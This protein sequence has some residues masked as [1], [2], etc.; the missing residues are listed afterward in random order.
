MSNYVLCFCISATTINV[1]S[2]GDV[3]YD[4]HWYQL[5]HR[6][7]F[8]VQMIIQRS[9]QQFELKAL[10][11]FVCSLDTYLKVIELH[12]WGKN[13]KKIKPVLSSSVVNIRERHVI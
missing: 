9:Q 11:I 7:Q 13:R 6:Q 10:S 4:L 5:P 12:L 8:I 1:M 3:I 2:L